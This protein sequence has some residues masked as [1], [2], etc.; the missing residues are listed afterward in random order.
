LLD[1]ILDFHIYIYIYIYN[2]QSRKTS[3]YKVLMI[4]FYKLK[5]HPVSTLPYYFLRICR[6]AFIIRERSQGLKEFL[7]K[8]LNSIM[9]IL[10][11]K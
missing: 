3:R 1:I 7:A 11:A 4:L 10:P 5:H 2:A 6:K 9:V 8:Q